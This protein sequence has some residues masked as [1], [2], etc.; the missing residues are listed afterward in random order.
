MMWHPPTGDDGQI[1]L[2]V[3]IHAQLQAIALV[4]T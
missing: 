1:N 3:N 4:V 2:E